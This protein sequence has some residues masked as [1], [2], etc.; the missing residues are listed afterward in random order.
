MVEFL[1]ND[2]NFGHDAYIVIAI[3]SKKG[4][5]MST[6]ADALG[7]TYKTKVLSGRE[8]NIYDFTLNDLMEAEETLG[9]DSE[10]W[11]GMR[12]IRFLTWLKLRKCEPDLTEEQVGDMVTISELDNLTDVIGLDTESGNENVEENA[13]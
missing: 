2:R 6:L 11:V 1:S 7:R 10:Q 4:N 3:C 8:W 5:R 12:A 13:T 9:V